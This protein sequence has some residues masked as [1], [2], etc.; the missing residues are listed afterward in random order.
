MDKKSSDRTITPFARRQINALDIALRD[1]SPAKENAVV[2]AVNAAPKLRRRNC[3]P[4]CRQCSLPEWQTMRPV[5]R[6]LHQKRPAPAF[7]FGWLLMIAALPVFIAAQSNPVSAHA[8]EQMVALTLPTR[9]YFVGAVL[10][11]I[12][13][14]LLGSFARLVP[15]FRTYHLLSLNSVEIPI[16]TQWASFTI[17]GLM[18]YS[19]L[20]GSHDPL[21]NPLSLG[22]W[23]GLWVILPLV[24]VC[25]GNAWTLLNPWT[26]PVLFVRRKF[27]LHRSIG[28]SR[29][30]HWPACFGFFAFA[31][32]EIVHLSPA[33]PQTLAQIVAVYWFLIFVLA[34]LEGDDWLETGEA[35]TLYF[36]LLSRIAPIWITT[37]HRQHHLKAGL[38]GAQVLSMRP[39]TP[40]TFAFIALVLAAV[41]FDGLSETFWW[42]VRLGINPL[43]FPGRSAV[44]MS[45]SVGLVAM[46]ILVCAL[47]YVTVA[48][49]S[50]ATK[51]PDDGR[52]RL[53]RQALTLL[54][55]SA[56]YHIAHYLI[57]LLTNGQYVVEVINDPLGNGQALL[58]LDRHWVSFAFL[59][60][61]ETVRLIW[62][63]Q[64]GLVVGAHV[65]AIMLAFRLD[66]ADCKPVKPLVHAPMGVLMIAFTVFGLWL[67]TTATGT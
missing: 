7:P 36:S 57:A 64:F 44:F 39:T 40:G 24:T 67:L 53:A 65:L 1:G 51:N 15:K 54:P 5:E 20:F 63:V 26:G 30:G 21:T 10:T 33:D 14:V 49:G 29:L 4:N 2:L 27:G 56:G 59:T 32:L 11:I 43:E 45:N 25:F 9:A 3:H 61:P 37:R 13:T 55:I 6:L 35:F 31:W 60:I 41:S 12:S 42:L 16:Y 28:I 48:I 46:W 8:T 52:Q 22:I 66:D 23:I 18:I 19:G 34:V 58:G 50:R 17:L 38:P 47:I 62:N